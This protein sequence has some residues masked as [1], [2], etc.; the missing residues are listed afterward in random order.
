MCAGVALEGFWE[1]GDEVCVP[2]CKAH[3]VSLRACTNSLLRADTCHRYRLGHES[4]T[5][6]AEPEIACSNL[7]EPKQRSASSVFTAVQRA[8]G[9]TRAAKPVLLMVGFGVLVLQYLPVF[10]RASE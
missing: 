8:L 10:R 4:K 2:R 3:K 5:G 9:V 6:T 7:H 1:L